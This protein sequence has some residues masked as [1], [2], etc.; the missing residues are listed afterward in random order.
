VKPP[1]APAAG[2]ITSITTEY[3]FVRM[4]PPLA[5]IGLAMVKNC[6]AFSAACGHRAAN[7]LAPPMVTGSYCT[8]LTPAVSGA[9]PV[10]GLRFCSKSQRPTG[11]APS[12]GPTKTHDSTATAP[13]VINLVRIFPVLPIEVLKRSPSP[14]L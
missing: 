4:P 12:A 5:P 9:A 1:L 7:P 8:G 2:N 6:S 11:V 13:A 14:S 3:W 10:V